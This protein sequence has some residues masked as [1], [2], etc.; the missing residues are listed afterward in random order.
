[1]GL[2]LAVD[3]G[4]TNVVLGIFDLTKGPDG[5]L[6]CSWRLATSRERT[7][8]EYGLS[9]LALMR[10]HGIEAS[11]IK[12]VAISCVV[13]PLHPV[14]MGLAKTYFDVDAFYVEPGVK[15]G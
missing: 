8:D 14:L 10:H 5:P 1:M 4:N 3:V 11:Q 15:T 13:P 12:H 6:I 2:L 9:T 7:I